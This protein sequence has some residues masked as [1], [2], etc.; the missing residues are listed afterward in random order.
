MAQEALADPG[1]KRRGTAPA[2]RDTRRCEGAGHRGGVLVGEGQWSIGRRNQATLMR[3]E[4]D[5]AAVEGGV[6][7]GGG[8]VTRSFA[9]ALAPAA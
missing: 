8:F 1:R 5:D 6:I 4:V 2:P 9:T 3:H 7:D